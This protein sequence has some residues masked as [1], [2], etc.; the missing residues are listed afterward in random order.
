[1]YPLAASRSKAGGRRNLGRERKHW[2]YRN[3]RWPRWWRRRRIRV[4]STTASATVATEHPCAEQ[5]TEQAAGYSDG[6]DRRAGRADQC[7]QSARQERRATAEALKA[8]DAP[9]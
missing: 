9:T 3:E 7:E 8:D 6:A 5:P 4:A 2:G 1:P